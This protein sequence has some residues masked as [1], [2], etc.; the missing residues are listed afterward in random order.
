MVVLSRWCSSLISVRICTRSLA[1]R[2][3]SGSSNRNTCG[4]RTMARPMA[5]R[6][7]WPPEKLAQPEDLGRALDARVDLRPGRAAQPHREAHV[8][9]DRHVRIERVVLKHHRDV[10]LARRQVGDVA[11]ATAGECNQGEE[12][13]RGRRATLSRS[14]GVKFM[15]R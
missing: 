12:R 2:F 9:G 14:K 1:S 8:V 13:V 15:L 4:S 10:A 7:R 5:T 11:V 6:W 3:D